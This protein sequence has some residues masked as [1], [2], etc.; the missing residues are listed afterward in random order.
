M[1]DI[2]ARLRVWGRLSAAELRMRLGVSP[3]TLMRA[4]REAGVKV[5]VRGRARR[6]TYAA[7]RELRGS[8]APIPVYRIDENG[9]AHE[10]GQL[11]LAYPDGSVLDL[12]AAMEWPTLGAEMADGWHEGIP[13]PMLDMRPQGFLGRGFARRNAALLQVDEDPNRWSDDDALHALTLLGHDTPGNFILGEPAYRL[14]LETVRNPPEPI[15]DSRVAERYAEL[16]TRAMQFGDGGS[17]A[18]GEFPKFT[19]TRRIG[20]GA[21][22]THVIVKFSGNDDSAG[23]QRWADLL[24]CEHLAASLSPGV[25]AGIRAST[26]TIH[27]VAGRTFLEVE[28]F[29]RH[30]RHGRSGLLSLH[31][32]NAA[33]VGSNQASWPATVRRLDDI[34]LLQPEVLEQSAALWH[35]GKL[36]ANDDMHEGNL[37]F[38]PALPGQ[39]GLRLAPVYDMLPMRYAPAR[40]VEIAP[41]EFEP[42]LPLPSETKIWLGAARAALEFW[43]LASGDERISAG[44]RTICAENALRIEKAMSSPVLAGAAEQ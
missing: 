35:F 15:G 36:I 26:S 43:R 29:D 25:L 39:T 2:V 16:A 11:N 6:S 23:T 17:S 30:G 1:P 40:G 9:A 21:D 12:T 20:A 41:R 38:Q 24:V 22:V 31:A 8:I 44:F 37:S 4:A 3:A 28:R 42:A 32:L 33:L 34:G 13:Y 19:T 10:Q 14:W 18:A 7:R 5:I 27:Q